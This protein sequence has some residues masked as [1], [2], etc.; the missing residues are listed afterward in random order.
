[1]KQ[2]VTKLWYIGNRDVNAD[3]MR[4]DFLATVAIDRLRAYVLRL[5]PCPLGR[6]DDSLVI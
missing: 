4:R 3:V 6:P 2:G 1:V 5:G